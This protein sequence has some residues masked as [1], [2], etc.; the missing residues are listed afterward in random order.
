MI[1]R[2]NNVL[3]RGGSQFGSNSWCQCGVRVTRS[4]SWCQCGVRVFRSMS[5]CQCGVRVTIDP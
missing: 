4:I 1:G 3:M 5:W 2:N